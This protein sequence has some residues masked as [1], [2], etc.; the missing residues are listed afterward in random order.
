M[1]N[2]T[3]N[4][5]IHTYKLDLKVEYTKGIFSNILLGFLVFILLFSNNINATSTTATPK[6]MG[7]TKGQANV[8]QGDFSYKLDIKTPKGIANLKPKLS[9]NYNQASSINSILGKSFFLGGLGSISKCKQNLFKEKKDNSRNYNY[10]L[11]GQKLLLV[12]DRQNDEDYGKSNTQYKTALNPTQKIIK[13]AN[14]WE[15][16]TKDGLIYE[17]GN[18]ENSNEN[19]NSKISNIIYKLSTI[20]DRYSNQ[21]RYYYHQ[22]NHQVSNSIKKIEYSNSKIEFIYENRSDK[23]ALYFKGTKKI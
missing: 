19:P 12:G 23:R 18:N 20:K 4:K 16:Y 5:N 8:N 14:H 21:I 22:N 1:N 2:K 6:L 3:L 9:I 17:Y 13:K 11:N 7:A 10:C 15:V